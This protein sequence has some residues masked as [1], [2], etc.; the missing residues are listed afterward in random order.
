M[1]QNSPSSPFPW[2]SPSRIGFGIGGC[3]I[4]TEDHPKEEGA[5]KVGLGCYISESRSRAVRGEL[6]D[7]AAQIN[8]NIATLGLGIKAM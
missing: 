6:A 4:L 1:S 5:W 7:L 2:R 3:E 8:L